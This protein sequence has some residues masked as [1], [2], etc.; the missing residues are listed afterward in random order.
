MIGNQ[1]TEAPSG[2]LSGIGGLVVSGGSQ[3]IDAVIVDKFTPEPATAQAPSSV[4]II[5]GEGLPFGL[6]GIQAGAGIAVIAVAVA[7]LLTR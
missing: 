5:S 3:F 7:Y 6:S 1:T 4:P 2:F